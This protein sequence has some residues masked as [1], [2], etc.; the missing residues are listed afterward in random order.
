M[1]DAVIEVFPLEWQ[2]N[3]FISKKPSWWPQTG[4]TVKKAVLRVVKPE[5]IIADYDEEPIILARMSRSFK[6]RAELVAVGKGTAD[7]NYAGIDV[8][9]KIVLAS[10]YANTVHSLAVM[11]RDAV[12]IISFGPSSYNSIKGKGYPDM[13]VWQVL[14]PL[15]NKENKP[16][17]AFSISENKGNYLLS[18][19]AGQK[20]VEVDVDIQT[21][22]YQN[23]LKIVNASIQ[24]K[25][26]S[27]EEF[28]F[29]AHLDHVK[30][31][32]GD[33][34]SGCA[35]LIEIARVITKLIDEGKIEQP[36]RTIRFI[37]G[38]EG[39][40]SRMYLHAHFDK[41]KT[42]LCGLNLDMVGM[43]MEK[44]KS[45]FRIIKNPDSLPSFMSDLV[46]N[47]IENLDTR[48]VK[49]P[50]G[51][52]NFLN[53]RFMPYSAS[54]DHFIF[55]DGAVGVPMMMFNY[56]PDE[57]HHTNIDT[58]DKLDAT[59]LKR[60]NFLSAATA[61]FIVN[62]NDKDAFDLANVVV[63]NGY[64]RIMRA[65]QKGLILLRESVGNNVL[66]SYKAG[67]NYIRCCAKR[68]INAVKTVARLAAE[69]RMK[70]KI[71]KLSGELTKC[72]KIALENLEKVYEENC[73]LNDLEVK[74]PMLTKIEKEGKKIVPR[75][76]GRFLNLSW[77]F[78]LNEKN[79]DDSSQKFLNEFKGEFLDYYIR[80]PEL[81]NF[82]DNK[83]NLLEIRDAVA[84]EYFGFMT[85]NN[86]VGHSED[87]S[88][89]YRNLDMNSLIKLFTIFK[90]AELVTF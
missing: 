84:A 6:G 28:L 68:E 79:L 74:K 2:K 35:A 49:A 8:K 25:N 33:N 42:T 37:W 19:L 75:R 57:F 30:P 38:P 3:Y 60:I 58:P 63:S 17:Y 29:Y 43:D 55:N 41:L 64:G 12:G 81:L 7:E 18:L 48:F 59:E 5:K 21:E 69:N 20:K 31:S 32:A 46:Q 80:I 86:Y 15:Q 1:K 54:S 39:P 10:G 11:K 70:T 14:S 90:K 76:I 9:G 53:Y 50:T 66:D 56:S 44:T 71:K 65:F 88:Q 62:A 72:E 78:I 4:W 89:K 77:Q 23:E 61:L 45:I 36:D 67:L 26:N 40:G 16:Q 13:E 27:D 52:R 22:F 85:A 34:A 73:F 24:G 47:L 83:N 51:K 87:I 82:V